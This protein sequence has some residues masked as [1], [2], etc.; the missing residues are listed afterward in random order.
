[1]GEF[2]L[3]PDQARRERGGRGASAL[4]SGT[5]GRGGGRRGVERGD[6]AIPPPVHRGN[7]AWAPGMVPQGLTQFRNTVRQHA[8]AHHR[9]RPYRLQERVFRHQLA[10]VRHQVL[11]HRTGFARQG[12]HARAPAQLRLVRLKGIGPKVNALMLLH[13]R[14]PLRL[15]T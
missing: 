11:Q 10:G 1:M 13:V 9:L 5:D 4:G 8:L 12:Q 3:A 2:G 6:K 15:R 14:V 7:E